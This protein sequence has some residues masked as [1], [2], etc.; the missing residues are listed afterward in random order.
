MISATSV[1]LQFDPFERDLAPAGQGRTAHHPDL[2]LGLR[3]VVL[4]DSESGDLAQGSTVVGER[5]QR[6]GF[7]RLFSD[8]DAEQVDRIRFGIDGVLRPVMSE[9]QRT[10]GFVRQVQ[11]GVTT[12][13]HLPID[14]RIR[15]DARD[16]GLSQDRFESDLDPESVGD[17]EKQTALVA[18]VVHD[19]L[20]LLGMNGY[21][22]DL[23][24]MASVDENSASNETF[25]GIVGSPE[26]WFP[27][28]SQ[29]PSNAAVLRLSMAYC[30]RCQQRARQRLVVEKFSTIRTRR[31]SRTRSCFHLR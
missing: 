21:A 22:F 10:Q 9:R 13:E 23:Q 17:V 29:W 27:P 14:V 12:S 19:E 26:C 15:D 1:R 3:L 30:S 2:E 24:L 5:D 6:D 18:V 28:A 25:D 16:Q 4:G 7:A 20:V 8:L 11:F 31:P